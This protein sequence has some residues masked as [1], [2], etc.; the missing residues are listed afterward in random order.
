M[1]SKPIEQSKRCELKLFNGDKEIVITTPT[2][3]LLVAA[4]KAAL[5]AH[6]KAGHLKTT[7]REFEMDRFAFTDAATHQHGSVQILTDGNNGRDIVRLK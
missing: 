7:I 6:G 4:L 2:K 3:A 1:T 5:F